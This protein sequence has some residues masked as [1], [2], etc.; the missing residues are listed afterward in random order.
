VFPIADV[1]ELPR[2]GRGVI[3]MKLNEGDTLAAVAVAASDETLQI[4]CISKTGKETQMS[5]TPKDVQIFLSAR[6]RKGEAFIGRTQPVGFVRE[7]PL[8]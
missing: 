4:R 2:G 6:A 5:V 3:L 1:N 8:K 7:T